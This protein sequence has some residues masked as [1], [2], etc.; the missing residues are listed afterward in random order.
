MT[1]SKELGTKWMRF[2]Y[3]LFVFQIIF[4]ICGVLNTIWQ[5]D[6]YK[7]LYGPEYSVKN[8]T[9]LWIVVGLFRVIFKIA[10]LVS[11]NKPSGCNL[12]II[13]LIIDV[14]SAFLSGLL[15]FSFAVGVSSSLIFLAFIIPS[16]IYFNKRRFMYKDGGVSQ[17]M[18]KCNAVSED[19]KHFTK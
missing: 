3:G 16:I 2:I 14:I 18:K 11:K 8:I 7:S 13:S 1:E 5:L 15:E 6:Y 12:V 17:I 9:Y 19:Y 10:S 4:G